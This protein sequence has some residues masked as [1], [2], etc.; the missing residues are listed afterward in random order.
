[1]AGLRVTLNIEMADDVTK[2]A[3]ISVFHQVSS[4][5]QKNKKK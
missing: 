3:V 1:L 2:D 5:K 4:E